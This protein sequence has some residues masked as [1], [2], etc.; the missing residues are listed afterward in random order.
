MKKGRLRKWLRRTGIG[1]LVLFLVLALLWVFRF[2][3]FGGLIRNAITDGLRAAGFEA[4]YGELTGSLLGDVT[5]TDFSITESPGLPAITTARVGRLHV[6]YSLVGLLLGQDRFIREITV[7]EVTL[8]LDLDAPPPPETTESEPGEPLAIDLIP[9][10]LRLSGVDLEIR[11]DAQRLSLSGGRLSADADRAGNLTGGFGAD[12]LLLLVEGRERRAT[13]ASGRFEFADGVATVLTVSANE[14]RIE[15]P[16]RVDLSRLEQSEIEARLHFPLSDGTLLADIRAGFADDPPEFNGR[17]RLTEVDPL[18]FLALLPDLPVSARHVTVDATF[19]TNSQNEPGP[20]SVQ[21]QFDLTIRDPVYGEHR[22]QAI[23]A[24]CTL[25][26]GVLTAN[27]ELLDPPGTFEFEGDLLADSGAVKGSLKMKGLDVSRLLIE[28]DGRAATGVVDVQA[29]VGGTTDAPVFSARARIASPALGDLGADAIEFAA[30][31]DLDRVTIERLL[32]IRGADRVSVTGELSPSAEPPAFAVRAHAEVADLSAYREFIPTDLPEDLTGSLVLDVTANGTAEE[33]GAIITAVLTGAG[34]EGFFTETIELGAIVKTAGS[35]KLKSLIIKGRGHLPDVV[36]RDATI[37]WTDAGIRVEAP[38]IAVTRED[39]LLISNIRAGI[40]PGGR[41]AAEVTIDGLDVGAVADHFGVDLGI[42]GSL[43]GTIIASGTPKSPRAVLDIKVREPRSRLE[44]LPTIA[45]QSADLRVS[46]ESDFLTLETLEIKGRRFDIAASARVPFSLDAAGDLSAAPVSGRVR[47][48]S[49]PTDL[50]GEIPGIG[51]LDGLV[52]AN[53]TIS[54]RADDP[55]VSGALRVDIDRL[56]LPGF[57]GVPLTGIG[58]VLQPDDL[59]AGGGRLSIED[60][61]LSAAGARLAASGSIAHTN[62]KIV[63]PNL[64]L[65]ITAID[66]ARI[67]EALDVDVPVTGSGRFGLRVTPGPVVNLELDLPE[68]ALPDS[69]GMVCSIGGEWRDGTFTFRESMLANQSRTVRIDGTVPFDLSLSPPAGGP[70]PDREIAVVLGITGLDLGTLPLASEGIRLAGSADAKVEVSGILPNPEFD[71]TLTLADVRFRT[72]G[73]PGID[74][75]GGTIR[76]NRER[77]TIER[78]AGTLGRGAFEV[79]GDVAINSGQPGAANL[80]IQ[81]DNAQLVRSEGM[82]LRTDLDLTLKGTGPGD[83]TVGGTVTVRSLKVGATGL[84]AAQD[85]ETVLSGLK[86]SPG[87]ATLPLTTDPALKDI[88]LD[89]TLL[90]PK[91]AVHIRTNLVKATVKGKLLVGGTLAIPRPRGRI[92]VP[93]GTVFLIAGRLDLLN[94]IVTFKENEPLVPFIDGRAT[95]RVS[96]VDVFVNV[97]GPAYN[98]KVLFSS[99]PPHPTPDIVSLILTGATRSNLGTSALS[100]M[101]STYLLRQLSSNFGDDD[102]GDSAVSDLISRIEVEFDDRKTRSG[103]IP[104]FTATARILDWLFVRG[105][106]E[107]ALD[108]GF[109]L[110]FRLTFP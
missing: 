27:G 104:G 63:D 58:V 14:R 25:D 91:G 52:N 92:Y 62:G 71:G 96:G 84:L 108:Y 23:T 19:R 101:A 50:A 26:G 11:L 82:R 60:L 90:I 77:I 105:Q 10:R 88:R 97:S 46:Y 85:I 2:P 1:V 8:A 99:V 34:A 83:L 76:F 98:A 18:P 42:S 67:R 35:V 55:R 89:L 17:V 3:L 40:E 94:P 65:D 29:T 13:D 68:L 72:A 74:K 43:T 39:W 70:S 31:G 87:L 28:V 36:L 53:L 81:A 93:E 103:G 86:S 49:L 44:N 54:G 56:V 21:A 59:G 22:L 110:I 107:S 5:V 12:E 100:G 66:I 30:R 9:E 32:V 57:E 6:S 102:G 41:M 75:L 78:L 106:Q 45:A 69:P 80:R 15:T 64:T 24:R 79:T 33:P 37:E 20:A 109:D 73:A 47:I 7:A 38:A 48:S 61:H 4:N 95:A 51:T 16:A